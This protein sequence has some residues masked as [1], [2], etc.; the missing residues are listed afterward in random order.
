MSGN[1]C[2]VEACVRIKNRTTG[3]IVN[4][5]KPGKQ[6]RRALQESEKTSKI[7]LKNYSYLNLIGG[8]YGASYTPGIVKSNREISQQLVKPYFLV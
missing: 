8:D 3:K 4:K 5:R 2:I 1:S 6:L 7:D